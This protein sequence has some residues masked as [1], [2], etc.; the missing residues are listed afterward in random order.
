MVTLGDA[1]L[2]L[3]E[4]L[5]V[6]SVSHF[7]GIFSHCPWA[8]RLFLLWRISP[9]PELFPECFGGVHHESW[10]GTV[11]CSAPASTPVTFIHILAFGSQ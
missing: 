1:A 2:V 5:G 9:V 7:P 11:L 8:V 3:H 4:P 10:C 6:C